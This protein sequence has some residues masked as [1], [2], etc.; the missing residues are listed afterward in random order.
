MLIFGSFCWINDPQD[1]YIVYEVDRV[2]F[3]FIFYQSYK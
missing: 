3:F 1:E 2:D